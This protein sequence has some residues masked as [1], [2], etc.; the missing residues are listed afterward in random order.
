MPVE[1]IDLY[2]APQVGILIQTSVASGRERSG[3]E[4]I[5]YWQR[6][7]TILYDFMRKS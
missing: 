7:V 1:V 4:H 5:R 2:T 6:E 3:R